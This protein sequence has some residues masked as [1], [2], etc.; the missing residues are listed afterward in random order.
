MIDHGM[1]D[2]KAVSALSLNAGTDMDMVG[3]GY[4]STFM[5]SVKEGVPL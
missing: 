4:F 2:L 5:Q 3:E 1:G